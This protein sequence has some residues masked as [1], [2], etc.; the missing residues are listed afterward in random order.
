MLSMSSYKNIINK[1]PVVL[2]CLTAFSITWGLKLIYFSVKSRYGMPLFNFG[3]ISSFGPS[4]SAL[5]LIYATEGKDGFKRIFKKLTDWN[6]GIKW[7]LLATFFEPIMFG[8]ITLGYWLVYGGF[9]VPDAFSVFLDVTS[10]TGTFIAGLFLWGLSEEIGWRGW[11]L[12]KLQG[13][14]SPL[15]ASLILAVIA[16]LWHINPNLFSEILVSKEGAYLYGFFPEI[17]ERLFISIPFTMVITY[18]FNKTSGSL[19]LMMSF[20]SASNTSYFWIDGVFG[21]VKSD[22]FRISFTITLIIIAIV[23]TVMLIRQRKKVTS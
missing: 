22:F 8:I 21:I 18:I 10:Y 17:V 12:P 1:F 9:P 15:S 19:L 4:I 20:H 23:F 5:I 13:G 14:M 2:Y 11:M 16:S 6:V 3:L 7:I